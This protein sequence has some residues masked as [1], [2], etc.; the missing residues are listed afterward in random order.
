MENFLQYVEENKKR[1]N[2]NYKLEKE[3]KT[4]NLWWYD[5]KNLDTIKLNANSVKTLR[6]AGLN[7][8]YNYINAKNLN[9]KDIKYML[10][11]FT[12]VFTY[13][14]NTSVKTA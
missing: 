5:E 1:I 11:T 14:E 7:I 4:K 3:N 12:D 9:Y 13:K 2:A 6:K 8:E 10:K